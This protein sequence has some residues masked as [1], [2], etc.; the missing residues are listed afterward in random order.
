MCVKKT[1]KINKRSPRVLLI[2]FIFVF[3]LFFPTAR[4]KLSVI[5]SGRKKKKQQKL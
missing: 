5:I 3:F 2:T 1:K 4:V